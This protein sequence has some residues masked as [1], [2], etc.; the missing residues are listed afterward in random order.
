MVPHLSS[1]VAV[2]AARWAARLLA[3][4]L[5]LFWGAFFVAHLVEWYAGPRWPPAWVSG[6]VLLHGLIVLGLLAGWRW[7]RLGAALTLGAAA[8]FFW[9]AAG[10]NFLPFLLVTAVPPA[11]WLACAW[12]EARAPGQGVPRGA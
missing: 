6:L 11:L 3:A 5:A 12:A 1:R 7:E 10:R 4:G 8:P 2:R 9:W